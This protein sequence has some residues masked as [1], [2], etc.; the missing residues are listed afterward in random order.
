[1]NQEKRYI[2]PFFKLRKLGVLTYLA[3]EWKKQGDVFR[4]RLG[5]ISPVV[6]CHP[7]GVERILAG[8][9]GNYVKGSIYSGARSVLGN[10]LIT[11]VGADWRKRRTLMQPRFHWARVG[12]F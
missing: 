1:M 11:S 8:N 7:D 6:V 10:G 9:V 2:Q 5:P 12:T 3:E 4:A